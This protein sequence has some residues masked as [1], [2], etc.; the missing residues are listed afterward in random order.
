MIS[1]TIKEQIDDISRQIIE[2]YKPNKIILFGSA[3]TG[4]FKKDSDLDFIVIKEDTPFLGRERAREL[5]KLI[6]KKIPADFLIYRPAEFKK[7][8]ELGDPFIKA[9]IKQGKVL[10]GS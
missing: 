10:Y 9:V 3:A 5:R 1:E 4:D 7:R 8:E 2:K 6:L